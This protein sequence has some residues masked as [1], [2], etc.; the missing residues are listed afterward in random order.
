VLQAGQYIYI[1][2]VGF[3]SGVPVPVTF[4]LC[5]VV[6]AWCADLAYCGARGEAGEP[7]PPGPGGQPLGSGM[8]WEGRMLIVGLGA[9]AGLTTVAYL[10][11][12]S[13]LGALICFRYRA[14]YAVVRE[15]DGR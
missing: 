10:G 3:A 1:V 2:A 8:G 13:Y 7:G 11:L 15:G 14:S 4:T 5:L 12:A 6:A 9:I